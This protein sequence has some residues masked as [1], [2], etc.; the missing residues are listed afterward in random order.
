MAAPTALLQAQNGCPSSK[1]CLV[2]NRDARGIAVMLNR[3]GG[4]GYRGLV[5]QPEACVPAVAS[6]TV[7][8][9]SYQTMAARHQTNPVSP[10]ILPAKNA[11]AGVLHAEI[12][13]VGLEIKHRNNQ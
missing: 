1:A 8:R 13:R 12:A 4:G 3:I 7:D 2:E 10:S 9:P 6:A 5:L 11:K